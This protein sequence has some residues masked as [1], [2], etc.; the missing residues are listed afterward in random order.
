MQTTTELTP[1]IAKYILANAMQNGIP[2]ELYLKKI[3]DDERLA[4]MSEAMQDELFLADFEEV[5]EDFKHA[6][7]E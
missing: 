5:A 6:D 1:N 7:F 4:A 2:V 3:I